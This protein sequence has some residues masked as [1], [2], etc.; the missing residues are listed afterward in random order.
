MI[1]FTTVL[2]FLRK[3]SLVL[4]NLIKSFLKWDSEQGRWLSPLK[5][6]VILGLL[7]Y[8]LYVYSCTKV[9]CPEIVTTT[10]VKHTTHIDTLSFPKVATTTKG[11]K[12]K[13][14][15]GGIP[16]TDDPK[17]PCDSLF[18]YTQE[19]DDS[20]ITGLLTADVKGELV[21]SSFT[22]T[23]KFPKYIYR[24]DTIKI[25]ET[26]KEVIERKRPYGLIIGGGLN[27]DHNK[28]VGFTV[29]AGI[30]LKQGFDIIYR[31]DPMRTQ[32][33]LGVTYTFEFN[34]RK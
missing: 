28:Y 8:I 9:N 23:P 31:F 30:Q 13:K 21:G 6:F 24:V 5:T 10:S 27:A 14:G 33:S 11:K 15:K 19:Y 25:T 18:Q 2:G 26:I 7:A 32:H 1:W 3:S 34:K 16:I 29:E 4:F 20:L 17:T 22:Y 12:P